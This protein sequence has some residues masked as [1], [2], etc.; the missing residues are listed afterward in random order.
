MA[1]FRQEIGFARTSD[2]LRIAYAV[3]GRGDPLVRCT[4]WLT[5]I[6][7]DWK[8]L[9]LGPWLREIGVRWHLCRYNAR[10]CGLSEGEGAPLSIDSFVADVE[11]LIEAAKLDRIALWGPSSDAL[12]SHRLPRASSETK[13]TSR[14]GSEGGRAAVGLAF[15]KPDLLRELGHLAKSILRSKEGG[16]HI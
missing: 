9:V 15:P 13:A 10:G 16:C 7:H 1:P 5:S 12:G 6:E 14:R 8:T 2:S 4:H 11:G 3:S